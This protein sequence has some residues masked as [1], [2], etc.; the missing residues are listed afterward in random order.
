M[1]SMDKIFKSLMLQET[2]HTSKNSCFKTQE[3]IWD[4]ISYYLMSEFVVHSGVLNISSK[5]LVE[6]IM[7]TA[8]H[9]QYET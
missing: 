3:P 6:D 1:Q 4:V 8:E 5:S 2:V 7:K 9:A